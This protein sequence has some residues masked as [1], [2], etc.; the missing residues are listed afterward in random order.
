MMK[1]SV[2]YTKQA[3]K[4]LRKMDLSVQKKIY[5]WIGENLEGCENPRKY[6]KALTANHKGEWSYRVGDYRIIAEIQ[7]DKIIILVTRVGH[8]REI[9]D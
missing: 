8:R 9:Y 3:E 7:D 6:G 5:S 2:S 1:Y 4:A